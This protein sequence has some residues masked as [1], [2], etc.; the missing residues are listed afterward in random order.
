MI[1][2]TGVV[3]LVPESLN[4]FNSPKISI[5]GQSSNKSNDGFVS[6]EL[7]IASQD[8]GSVTSS[9]VNIPL[10][11]VKDLMIT[12]SVDGA[13]FVSN[14]YVLLEQLLKGYLET[15]N[16]GTSFEIE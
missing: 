8:L 12:N 4:I 2:S 16:P 5:V 7:S 11:T 3:Q 9:S 1:N 13:T 15:L 6:L 10:D 14:L